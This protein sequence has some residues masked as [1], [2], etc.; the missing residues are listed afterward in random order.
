MYLAEEATLKLND[1]A[2]A[3]AVERRHRF[4]NVQGKRMPFSSFVSQSLAFLARHVLEPDALRQ[5]AH[6][7]ERYDAADMHQ[8]MAAIAAL[9]AFMAQAQAPVSPPVPQPLALGEAQPASVTKDTPADVLDVRYL[10]GVGPRL[11]TQLLSLGI[12]TVGQLVRHY[13]R[14]YLDYA[15][16]LPI[17][18]LMEGQTVSIIATV[19][20]VGSFDTKAKNLTI[21]RLTLSDRSGK[22]TASW[23]FSKKQSGLLHQFKARFETGTEVLVSGKVKWDTFSR[24]P[25][26]DRPEVEVLSYADEAE[27]GAG[28]ADSLHA[29]RIVPIYRLAQGLNMKTL[30]RAIHTAL[31][32]HAETLNDVIPPELLARHELPSLPQALRLIHF[33]PSLPDAE[34][35]RNRLVFEE[36]LLMQLRLGMLRLQLKQHDGALRLAPVAGGL[37]EQFTASLPFALTGAQARAFETIATD[38]ATD[39]TMNRLLQGDVGSGKTVVAALTLLRAVENGY[40]AAL[41][42]PTEILAEQHYRKFVEWLTPLGLRVGLVVGKA[43]AKQR[44]DTYS[45]LANGQVHVAVG[46]HALIQDDVAF[47]RLGAVVVDE[48]HRF[49]VRQR[50]RLREKGTAPELLTMTATPIPRTLALTVHGDMDV[51]VLDELPPGRS[52]IVTHLLTQKHEDEAWT[53]IRQQVER[54]RQAYVVFPLVEDSETLAARAAT[55]EAERLQTEVFP[56]FK[57]GLLHGKLHPADKDEVMSAFVAGKLQVLVATTVVEVGVDVPNATVMVIH[58]ADRFGLAQLHQLRGRVGRGA[59]QSY[60]L[61]MADKLTGETRQRL[62]VLVDSTDGFV[63]AEKDLEIRGPGDVMGTRQS[64]LPELLLADL[65]ADR[66]LLELARTEAQT[67]LEAD[68]TLAGHPA[69]RGALLSQLDEAGQVLAG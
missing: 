27:G 16:Q 17:A 15:K 37:V 34:P 18:S 68:P 65:L 56:Q 55:S 58:N 45:G 29:G 66:H 48:Q 57:V 60:C 50:L 26:F 42:A 64:G 32:E 28:Q 25:S 30:R 44:R 10:K 12:T 53:L 7:F 19:I 2:S 31:D 8:R 40:Q 14:Q 5:L 61:L 22:A 24:C 47:A 59:H 6:R 3:V 1:L 36:L 49:G 43:T 38:M 39:Q 4:I 41:M 21:V 52:P 9:E 46:T 35:A 62:Q 69:L 63:I 33:P 13:P 20:G 54:G 51:S 67:L 11:A 23:F